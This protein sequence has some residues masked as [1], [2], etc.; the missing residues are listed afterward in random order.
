MHFKYSNHGENFYRMLYALMPD[1]EKRKTIL[2]EEVV[3]ICKGELPGIKH[4]RMNNGRQF[5]C[6]KGLPFLYCYGI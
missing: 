4:N 6:N 2:D 3:V 5:L 1:W